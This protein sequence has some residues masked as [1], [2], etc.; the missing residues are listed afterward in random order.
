MKIYADAGAARRMA[1]VPENRNAVQKPA[2]TDKD[3]SARL[4]EG[5][6]VEY[7]GGTKHCACEKCAKRLYQDGSTDPGITFKAPTHIAPAMSRTQVASHERQ[8]VVHNTTKAKEMGGKVV[9]AQ[10]RLFQRNCSECGT[11]YVSG[12]VT[13]VKV[14]PNVSMYKLMGL[15]KKA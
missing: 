7:A 12:G 5:R 2:N 15:D 3:P 10:V 6:G 1:G 4:L 13:V 14:R 11:R 8:H 9:S